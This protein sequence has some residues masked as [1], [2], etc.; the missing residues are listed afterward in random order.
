MGNKSE[1]ISP[2]L[3]KAREEYAEKQRKNPNS[4]SNLRNSLGDKN[5]R[6]AFDKMFNPDGTFTDEGKMDWAKYS[7]IKLKMDGSVTYYVCGS[8][9]L[10]LYKFLCFY[11]MKERKLRLVNKQRAME[12][13]GKDS[14]KAYKEVFNLMPIVV[15]ASTFVDNEV[16]GTLFEESWGDNPGKI[17]AI[18]VP[19][20]TLYGNQMPFYAAKI[21]EYAR[22]KNLVNEHI[23][24]LAEANFNE[25]TAG[26]SLPVVDLFTGKISFNNAAVVTTSVT[27]E[28]V[29]SP[30][31]T[32]RTEDG[33]E[34]I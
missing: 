34:L 14:S 30:V 9:Q 11:I 3:K 28:G 7:K 13:A 31:K 5:I 26:K 17:L 27:S 33:S 32:Q 29:S 24:I 19:S 12:K 10:E 4:V 15:F 8:T 23:I 18:Y 25:F 2:V 6:K 20:T 1:D 22:I 16:K 21:K